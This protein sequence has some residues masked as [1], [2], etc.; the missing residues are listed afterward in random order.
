M[1]SK[2]K[3]SPGKTSIVDLVFRGTASLTT[4]T[5]SSAQHSVHVSDTVE[6][7][8]ASSKTIK[9]KVKYGDNFKNFEPINAEELTFT[10]LKSMLQPL[11]LIDTSDE[12]I[13]RY[14]DGEG[15]PIIIADDK[16]IMTAIRDSE[17]LSL[18]INRKPKVNTLV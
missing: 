10:K 9:I 6:P 5:K 8:Q 3:V 12:I 11:L 4:I 7:V 16:D 18:I 13:I 2:D 14:N 17:T 1:T 15:H